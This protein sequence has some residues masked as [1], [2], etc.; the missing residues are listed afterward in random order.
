M[1]FPNDLAGD[2]MGLERLPDELSTGCARADQTNAAAIQ[3][4]DC[5]N[6]DV[7]G[8]ALRAHLSFSHREEEGAAHGLALSPFCDHRLLDFL[9]FPQC[10]KR[11]SRDAMS[12]MGRKLT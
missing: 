10:A 1:A 4:L 9:S 2:Q 3:S 5:R 7:G 6:A 8:F 11:R 12:A